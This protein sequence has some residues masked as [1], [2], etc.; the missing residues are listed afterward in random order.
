MPVTVPHTRECQ[1]ALTAATT[2]RKKFFMT[3]GKHITLDSIFKS[4]KI[5]SQNVE[6]V[7]REKDRKRH[8]EYHTRHEAALP[9]L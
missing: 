6:A 5:A 1:E 2:H 3:R 4:A 8:L 9:V 7:E